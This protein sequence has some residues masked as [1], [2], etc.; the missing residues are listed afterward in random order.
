MTI[1]REVMARLSSEYNWDLTEEDSKT[2]SELASRIGV[3]RFCKSV[4]AYFN[5][6]TVTSDGTLTCQWRPKAGQIVALAAKISQTERWEE[7][8]EKNQENSKVERASN[9]LVAELMA[10][11]RK[12]GWFARHAHKRGM[13]KRNG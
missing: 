9:E 5:D 12:E 13:A 11:V 3:G 8:T 7:Q 2:W 1:F 10:E 4:A 6:N